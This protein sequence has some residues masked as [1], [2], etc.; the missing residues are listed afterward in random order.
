MGKVLDHKW[1][2]RM[3][4]RLICEILGQLS[5]IELNHCPTVPADVKL[6]EWDAVYGL[7]VG[8][9]RIQMQF[10]AQED[11]LFRMAK[12]MIGREPQDCLEVQEYA[13]EFFNILY[14]RFVSEL[15]EGDPAKKRVAPAQYQSWPHVSQL[16]IQPIHSIC[17]VSDDNEKAIF[18]W[19]ALPVE[20]CQ[21]GI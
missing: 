5:G 2:N 3:A 19:A 18:S 14:G 12:N 11:L 16:E 8:S 9:H 21:G 1:V 15:F 7:A 4:Q 17:F 13:T 6:N 20:C 10:R